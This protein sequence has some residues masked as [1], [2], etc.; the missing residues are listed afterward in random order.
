[1]AHR[2]RV[3][4]AALAATTLALSAPL[5]ACGFDV[6][7]NRVYTPAMGANARDASV[8]VLG[9][10][11]VANEAGAGNLVATFV[12]NSSTDGV[13]L[14]SV[15]S[16]GDPAAQ[17]EPQAID[18]GPRD[19]VNLADEGGLP[20]SGDFALGQFVPLTF[21]FNTGEGTERVD[22]Q[23]AVVPD[24]D[25]FAG[26]GPSETGTERPASDSVEPSG[27]P[28]ET[29]SSQPSGEPSESASGDAASN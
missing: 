10:V 15:E 24:S 11:I 12:N 26:L 28:S 8:D 19:A 2:S 25:E 7:T 16:A 17:V 21:T 27:A 22:M 13:E 3:R 29:G 4:G 5:T 6:A 18:L 14:V 23:V 9:A 20:T 1:M